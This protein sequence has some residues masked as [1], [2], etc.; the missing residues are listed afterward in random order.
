M[1]AAGAKSCVRRWIG[2]LSASAAV[3]SAA[4]GVLAAAAQ[5]DHAR[6]AV[7]WALD[8]INQ[9]QLPLDGKV[10]HEGTGTG[11]T[12]YIID[13]GV[14][15]SHPDLAGRVTAIG[16]FFAADPGTNVDDC[17]APDGHGT[18]NASLA[19][20]TRFGVAP[21]ARVA[22]LKAAGGDRC[23]GTAT[24]TERAVDWITA[25]AQAPAVVNISFRFDAGSLN[26][27]IHRSIAAGFLY[28]LSAGTAGEVTR[29]W[30]A[31]LP[32]EAVIVAGTDRTDRAMRA[33]YGPRLTL[34]AP[35]V[36]V[37]GA[38]TRDDGAGWT[39]TRAQSGDSYAAPLAAGAAALYVERHP[40]A[41]PRDIR[42]ALLAA[43]TPGVVTN[44]GA[45]PNR[46]LFVP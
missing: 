32:G 30:G 11:V 14:R 22:V 34:F 13:T 39:P 36:A 15:S 44:P 2:G 25:N 26:A 7:S 42:A 28:T 17:A 23:E 6:P 27:A 35:A 37:T 12:I 5:A 9:R 8:R 21:R 18:L 19:A 46:M 4:V 43:A 38:G 31:Q 40:G 33:D 41:T 3:A 20:G 10:D 29:Y 24:A 1:D 16:D 45:S